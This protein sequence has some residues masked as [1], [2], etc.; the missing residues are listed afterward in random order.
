MLLLTVTLTSSLLLPR[1][2]NTPAP[3]LEQAKAN[4]FKAMKRRQSSSARAEVESA[5]DQLVACA[6]FGSPCGLFRRAL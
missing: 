3:K 5:I 4:L 1:A 6:T 2:R